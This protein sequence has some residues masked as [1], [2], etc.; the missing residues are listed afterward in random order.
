MRLLGVRA[1]RCQ[2]RRGIENPVSC[3]RDVSTCSSEDI[4]A[5]NQCLGQATKRGTQHSKLLL[6]LEIAAGAGI[7]PCPA[8]GGGSHNKQ[9]D[10]FQRKPCA[11][12]AQGRAL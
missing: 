10:E 9:N 2:V 3:E 5:Q 11:T 12:V 6:A 1:R 4:E 8:Q 7:A